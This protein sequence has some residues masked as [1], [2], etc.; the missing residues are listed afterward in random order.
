MSIVASEII[1]RKS[2]VITDT[3]ANGGRMTKNAVAN[4][5]RNGMFPNFSIS[6]RTAGAI[7]RRKFFVHVANDDDLPLLD[8]LL[9]VTKPTLAGDRVTIFAATWDDA[10]ADI[11]ASPDRYGAATLSGNHAAGLGTLSVTLEDAGQV[12]FRVGDQVRIWDGDDPDSGEIHTV[13]AVSKTGTAATLTLADTIF[14][15]FGFA[16]GCP[17]CS[18]M[19]CGE[20][21]AAVAVDAVVSEGGDL[22]AAAVTVD[23]IGTI[24]QTVTLTFTSATAFLA[25]SDVLGSL[26][27]GNIAASF[28]PSNPDYAKP[29]FTVPSAAWGGSW[30]AGDT[31]TITTTPAAVPFWAELVC[32]AGATGH[33]DNGVTFRLEGGTA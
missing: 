31:V 3:D 30:E 2:A 27:T 25:S 7:R 26:G 21:A 20:V 5:S 13:T 33:A 4:N 11:P 10:Q 6:E 14:N 28:A 17:V 8:G 32:P 9:S 1:L 18:L 24:A 12:I 16:S 15:E 29:Y 19:D 22:S 23:S